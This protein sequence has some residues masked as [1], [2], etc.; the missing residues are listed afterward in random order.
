MTPE[1]IR[2]ANFSAFWDY[3]VS[4]HLNRANRRTH[5]L[6]TSLGLVWLLLGIA[7]V[8]PWFL[9]PGL[10]TG[11]AF[12]WFGHFVFEK[13]KPASWGSPLF[14]LWSFGSDWIMWGKMLTGRMNSEVARIHERGT[15][16]SSGVA[17]PAA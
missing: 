2:P 7:W 1:L 17:Q 12:A 4:Q 14:A 15:V 10:A 3:Y 5:F 11:Y 13:N 16:N 6:G 9:L 8:N